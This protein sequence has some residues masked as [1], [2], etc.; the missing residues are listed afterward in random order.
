MVGTPPTSSGFNLL[1]SALSYVGLFDLMICITAWTVAC[2]D[3]NKYLFITLFLIPMA[4]AAKWKLV[5]L[6]AFELTPIHE[7]AKNEM[8][9]TF[10]HAYLH[11]NKDVTNATRDLITTINSIMITSG[12]CGVRGP[13]DFKFYN[14]FRVKDARRNQTFMFEYPPACC[15]RPH[16]TTIHLLTSIRD[17]QCSSDGTTWPINEKGCFSAV[18]NSVYNDHGKKL[19]TL[20]LCLIMLQS[21]QTVLTIFV[22][23]KRKVFKTSLDR[24]KRF[25]V[26]T[27]R[28]EG[29]VRPRVGT[30]LITS[31]S[32]TPASQVDTSSPDT[33]ETQSDIS[34]LKVE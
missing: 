25:S 1:S 29:S 3:K 28:S 4:I 27:P 21:I 32:Y 10:R 30:S 8:V 15:V 31:T 22:L 11:R 12:C 19:L 24:I 14:P 9:A 16:N 17:G 23:L 33:S 2:R 26:A 34:N 7:S 18:F 20:L 6:I 5:D 13:E